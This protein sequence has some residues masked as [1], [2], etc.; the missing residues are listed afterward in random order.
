MIL[1]VYAL[2]FYCGAQLV[3]TGTIRFID[4]TVAMVSVFCCSVST[5]QQP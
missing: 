3:S 4:F 2:L 1:W 5:T